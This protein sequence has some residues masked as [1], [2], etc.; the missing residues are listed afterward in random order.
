VNNKELLKYE[1]NDSPFSLRDTWKLREDSAVGLY[2]W[3]TIAAYKVIEIV[4][5]ASSPVSVAAVPPLAAPKAKV[6]APSV[7]QLNESEKTIREVFKDELAKTQAADKIAL[8]KQFSTQAANTADDV[9]GR[10][11]L[12]I[13]SANLSAEGGDLDAMFAA[14]KNYPLISKGI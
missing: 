10:Y 13:L 2:L 3:S 5:G 8:A 4:D 7:E 11:M 12:L 14:L 6:A 9:A 1:F